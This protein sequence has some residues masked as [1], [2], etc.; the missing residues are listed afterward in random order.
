MNGTEQ[1]TETD[2]PSENI[3]PAARKAYTHSQLNIALFFVFY[4]L[5]SIG[6]SFFLPEHPSEAL[7][8]IVHY[9]I[10]YLIAFP[11]YLLISGRLETHPPEKHKLS[12]F[13]IIQAFFVCELIGIFGNLLGMAVNA[14]LSFLLGFNTTSDFLV[15]GIFGENSLLFMFLAVICAPFVEEMI[16]RKILIDRISKYG[17]KTAILISGIMFGLFHGNFTQAFYA[18]MLGMLFAFIYIRTGRIQYTIILHMCVNFWGTV[19]PYLTLHN[20]DINDLIQALLSMKTEQIIPMLSEMKYFI[21][22]ASSTYLFAFF[23]IVVLILNRKKLRVPQAECELP[24]GK[25]F[26]TACC[27]FGC[28]VLLAVCVYQFLRQLVALL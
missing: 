16:F 11:L 14:V 7:N 2:S 18:A 22:M 3:I 13:Q 27:N 1:F 6:V 10:M 12:V 19:M 15:G 20:H 17:N 4:L 25:R 24:K 5:I 23:G 26:V 21:V 28:P 9:G 8:Y